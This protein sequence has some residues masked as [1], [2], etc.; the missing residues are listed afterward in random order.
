[1][2]QLDAMRVFAA[3]ADAGSLSAASRRLGMPLATVSRKLSDLEQHLHASLLVRTTRR[4][5]LTDAGQQ[6]HEACHRLLADL[7]EADRTVI[8]EYCTPR[9]ELVITA[10]IVFGR[11]HVLPI[12]TEFLRAYPEIDVRLVLGDRVSNLLEDHLDLAVRIQRLPDSGYR[13]TGV[14]HIRRV[15]CASPA[16][17]AVQGEP[18]TPAMLTQHQCISHHMPFTPPAWSF[19]VDGRE[20]SLPIKPR[21]SVSTAE[22]AIDATIAGAG[23]TQVLSYQI[24]HAEATGLMQTVL[25]AFECPPIPVSLVYGAQ[26]RLPL[27]LRAFLDFAA[28]KLRERLQMA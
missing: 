9:G 23:I 26:R 6:Y 15:V 13:A 12:I 21:L 20:L 19:F 4:L 17:L 22:A 5:T 2:N 11:L 1:M 24:A 3:V 18:T 8:G 10:P 16:Y 28:P 14:G 7:D 27:K 25:A